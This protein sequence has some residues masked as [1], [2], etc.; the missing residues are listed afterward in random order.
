MALVAVAGLNLRSCSSL[1]EVFIDY[2]V[3]FG[4]SCYCSTWPVNE[5]QSKAVKRVK[6]ESSVHIKCAVLRS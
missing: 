4:V 1:G 3:L 2:T 6:A 5:K